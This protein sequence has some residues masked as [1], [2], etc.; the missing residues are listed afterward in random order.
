M[1]NT[2]KFWKI[3]LLVFTGIFII[4]GIIYMAFPFTNQEWLTSP[5]SLLRPESAIKR[6]LL[7]IT[8]IGTSKEDV[9]AVAQEREWEIMWVRDT[10]GYFMN[11]GRVCDGLNPFSYAAGEA[12]EVGTQS[13]RIHLGMVNLPPL[14][15]Y[16]CVYYAFD[17]DSKLIDIA[18]RRP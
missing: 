11:R 18:I 2:K 4:G 3:L 15:V 1:G 13:I 16:V 5:L 9:I 7:R 8:P 12:Y 14:G 17:D 10:A 6:D